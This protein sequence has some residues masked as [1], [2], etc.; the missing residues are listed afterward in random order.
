MINEMM[1]A[2][3][4]FFSPFEKLNQ[5]VYLSILHTNTK[6]PIK[7]KGAFFEVPAF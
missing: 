3:L 2:G 5:T 7:E 1:N 4:D 6:N